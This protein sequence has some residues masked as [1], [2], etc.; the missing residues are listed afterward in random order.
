MRCSQD[1]CHRE[2][3]KRGLCGA[4]YKRLRLRGDLPSVW[5]VH[6]KQETMEFLTASLVV[7]TDDCIEWPFGRTGVGYG[8]VS[9]QGKR[10]GPHRVVCL[11]AYGSPPFPNADAAHFVCGNRGCVN[12]RHLRWS[13]RMQNVDDARRHGRLTFGQKAASA[14]LTSDNVRAIRLDTRSTSVI[15]QEYGVW[16]HTIRNVKRGRTWAHLR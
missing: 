14:K 6:K 2:A 11:L 16:P 12:K 15:A 3:A 8:L 10:M 9:Y 7:E 4:C 5:Q 1:N 13:S